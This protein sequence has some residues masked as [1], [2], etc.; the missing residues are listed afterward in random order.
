MT[1]RPEQMSDYSIGVMACFDNPIA[2]EKTSLGIG[3]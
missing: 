3:H 2:I 1:L